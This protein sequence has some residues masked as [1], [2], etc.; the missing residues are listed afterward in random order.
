MGEPVQQHLMP[1][2]KY[3][4]LDREENIVLSNRNDAPTL[5]RNLHKWCLACKEV[6]LSKYATTMLHGKAMRIIT[7]KPPSIGILLFAT[8]GRTDQP[9]EP[10][11][12]SSDDKSRLTKQ[13]L[14]NHKYIIYKEYNK[15]I[16]SH[17]CFL[18]HARTHAPPTLC[19]V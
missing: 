7:W 17:H 10:T 6:T 3:E 15:C 4:E 2:K 12:V 19:F 18:K 13:L 8:R 16:N 1:L 9:W 5:F 11:P 14:A